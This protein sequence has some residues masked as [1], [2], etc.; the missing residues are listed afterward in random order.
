MKLTIHNMK[1]LVSIAL[2]SLGCVALAENL[3]GC[4][5]VNGLAKFDFNSFAGLQYRFKLVPDIE[6][7][8]PFVDSTLTFSQVHNSWYIVLNGNLKNGSQS[9]TEYVVDKVNGAQILQT[10]ISGGA[11]NSVRR[12]YTVIAYQ[13]NRYALLYL[14]GKELSTKYPGV[15]LRFVILFGNVRLTK[16]EFSAISAAD[17]KQNFQGKFRVIGSKRIVDLSTGDE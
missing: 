10:Q 11:P 16:E 5:N 8:K 3:P 9:N 13:P 4:K 7:T 1:F 17:K 12:A 6:D 2:L 14:C 15:D